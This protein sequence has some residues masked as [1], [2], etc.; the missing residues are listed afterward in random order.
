[1]GLRISEGKKED[2][3]AKVSL[4]A[5]LRIRKLIMVN[6]CLRREKLEHFVLKKSYY[7]R[8]INRQEFVKGGPF[9][10]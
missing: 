6:N 4:M 9:V 1:M 8:E 10:I 5:S 7:E 2:E 3:V